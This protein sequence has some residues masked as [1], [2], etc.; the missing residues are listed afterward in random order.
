MS[1]ELEPESLVFEP[2][3]EEHGQGNAGR[4][5]VYTPEGEYLMDIQVSRAGRETS[6][7]LTMDAGVVEP[8][9][10][11]KVLD[12]E[13][14]RKIIHIGDKVPVEG[15]LGD[16]S[17]PEFYEDNTETGSMF[18]CYTLVEED[19]DV[20]IENPVDADYPACLR[21]DGFTGNPSEATSVFS[22]Y[23]DKVSVHSL[24]HSSRHSS[25]G[26]VLD[27]SEVASWD[28][29]DWESV[30]QEAVD[31]TVEVAP[32]LEDYREADD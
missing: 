10:F 3:Y 30:M 15:Y 29:S 5:V 22:E 27:E 9:S 14:I 8:G 4:T 20:S 1:R 13:E 28:K 24:S 2:R 17:D 32:H 18:N 26:F 31:A 12:K 21:I 16:P 7:S 19:W 11:R 23:A 6:F 25:N